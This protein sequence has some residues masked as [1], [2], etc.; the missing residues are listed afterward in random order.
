MKQN[1]KGAIDGCNHNKEHAKIFIWK[2]A[3][4]KPRFIFVDTHEKDFERYFICENL[5]YPPLHNMRL[6]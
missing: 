1:Q 4:E 6:S 2:M 5:F 3:K